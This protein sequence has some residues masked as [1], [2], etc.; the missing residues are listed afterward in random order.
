M[1]GLESSGFIVSCTP[2][3][4]MA[5]ALILDS[6]LSAVISDKELGQGSGLDLLCFARKVSSV[7]FIM[8]S[9][10]PED[11]GTNA[12]AYLNTMVLTKPLNMKLLLQ[13]LSEMVASHRAGE[14]I[15]QKIE[16]LDTNEKFTAIDLDLFLSGKV[17]PYDV[18]LLIGTERYIKVIRQSDSFT[19]SQLSKLKERGVR[20]LFMRREDFQDYVSK[21]VGI[22]RNFPKIPVSPEKKSLFIKQTNRLISEKL[23]GMD[24]GKDGI[25]LSKDIIEATLSLVTS[26]GDLL[27]QLELLKDNRSDVFA[28]SLNVAVF[29]VLIAKKLHWTSPVTHMRLSIAGLFHD[30]GKIKLPETILTIPAEDLDDS[31]FNMLRGHVEV[32]VKML[33]TL[34]VIDEEI[35]LLIEQHHEQE[36]GAGFPR[37]IRKNAINPLAKVI[38]VADDFCQKM[39]E[40]KQNFATII[41]VINQMEAEMDKNYDAGCVRALKS[42]FVK[43]TRYAS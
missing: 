42:I 18:Y 32:G 10:D 27:L 6:S 17:L 3:F 36:A 13:D 5:Q 19:K 16:F 26:S 9:D 8:I 11:T 43:R 38:H 40:R 7:P 20:D 24:I 12:D 33:R 22:I 1:Q 23:I 29:S 2:S 15:S 39:S 41:E 34:N 21:N 28:H 35:L 14:T 37:G 30:I 25:T 31:E 4:D